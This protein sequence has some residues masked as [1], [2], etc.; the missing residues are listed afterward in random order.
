[1]GELRLISYDRDVQANRL[2]ETADGPLD[3]TALSTI[4]EA[5][6]RPSRVFAGGLGADRAQEETSA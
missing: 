6:I 5:D 3:A 4:T 1:M 2:F